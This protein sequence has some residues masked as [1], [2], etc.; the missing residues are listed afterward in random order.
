VV[1]GEFKLGEGDE[2]LDRYELWR[3]DDMVAPK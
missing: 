2:V 1:V 3:L